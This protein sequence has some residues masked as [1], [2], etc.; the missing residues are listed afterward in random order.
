M[1]NSEILEEILYKAHQ[2]GIVKDVFERAKELESKGSDMF[3]AYETAWS[4]FCPEEE[5][6]AYHSSN[7]LF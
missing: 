1:T 4:E 5:Y 2:L 6:K 7:S 3:I